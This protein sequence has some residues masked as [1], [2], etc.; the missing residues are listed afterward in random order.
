MVLDL[1][2]LQTV[3]FPRSSMPLH[4]F[5]QRYLEMIGACMESQ[6]PFGVIL[7]KSGRAEGAEPLEIHR[8]GTT[9]HIFSANYQDDGTMNINVAGRHRFEVVDIIE[10]DP[11]LIAEIQRI[12]WTDLDEPQVR[13]LT[14]PLTSKFSEY[15]G[16]IMALTGQWLRKMELPESPVAVAEYVSAG[17]QIGNIARQKLLA[18]TS[19]AELMRMQLELLDAEIAKLTDAVDRAQNSRSN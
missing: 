9:A 8:V 4:I 15:L 17:L 6:T 1:F 18:Q 3:L 7:L 5:E 12:R 2:P 19:I 11:R 16:L 13:D 10:S 14:S